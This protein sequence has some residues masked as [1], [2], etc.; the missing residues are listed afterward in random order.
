LV[1]Q[2]EELHSQSRLVKKA[3]GIAGN[4]C[5]EKQ[6]AVLKYLKFWEYNRNNSFRVSFNAVSGNRQKGKG[7]MDAFME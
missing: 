6:F 2:D 7:M 3:I 1:Y 5:F 4:Y